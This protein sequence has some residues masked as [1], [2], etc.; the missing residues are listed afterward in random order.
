MAVIFKREKAGHIELKIDDQSTRAAYRVVPD[1]D[2]PVI[3]Q[4]EGELARVLDISAG[5]FSCLCAGLQLNMRY[6][7]VL[8]LPDESEPIEAFADVIKIDEDTICR[9]RLIDLQPDVADRLHR[10]VLRRQ[11]VAIKAIRANEPD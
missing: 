10:Y 11:K 4:V 3:L 5:G 1:R 9:C 8:D 2:E 6:R 7:V